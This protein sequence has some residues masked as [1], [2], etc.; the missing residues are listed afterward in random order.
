MKPLR[1]KHGSVI[2]EFL[3]VFPCFL[4]LSLFTLEIGFMW[5]DKHITRLAAFEAARSL[6]SAP[7]PELTANGPET[8]PCKAPEAMAK[9]RQ[10]ALRKMAIITPSVFYMNAQLG[11]FRIGGLDAF[12]QAL[13]PLPSA[14]K[15]MLARWPTAA[16]FTKLLCVYDSSTEIVPTA[17]TY[18]R[19]PQTPVA[20]RVMWVAHILA[21]ASEADSPLNLQLKHDFFGI[22]GRLNGL[23][24]AKLRSAMNEGLSLI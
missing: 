8:D 3:F 2:V 18:Y 9:A 24:E 13:S 1:S 5:A 14:A 6:A 19:A 17:I 21:K 7:L 11:N 4:V 23:E 20:G 16:A 22:E 10:A 15:R 12:Q